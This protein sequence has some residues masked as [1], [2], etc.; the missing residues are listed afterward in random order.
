MGL[1]N[2]ELE[3]IRDKA[4]WPNYLA[5]SGGKGNYKNPSGRDMKQRPPEYK[6]GDLKT[7]PQS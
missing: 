5:F 1:I 2:N 7:M 6:A 3:R 4:T